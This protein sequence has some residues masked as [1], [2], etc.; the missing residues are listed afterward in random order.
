MLVLFLGVIKVRTWGCFPLTPPLNGGD[1]DGKIMGPDVW[2][3]QDVELIRDELWTV[4]RCGQGSFAGFEHRRAFF[5][6]GRF[7]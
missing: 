6:F 7:P 5:F 2:G 4:D 3:M 1:F